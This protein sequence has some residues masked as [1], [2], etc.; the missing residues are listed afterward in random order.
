MGHLATQFPKGSRKNRKNKKSTR[1]IGS[2]D[3]RQVISKDRGKNQQN[4]GK[5]AQTNPHLQPTWLP[6]EMQQETTQKST[7]E[8]SAPQDSDHG[9]RDLQTPQSSTCWEDRVEGAEV[10]EQEKVDASDQ[11]NPGPM[12]TK[13]NLTF[14]KEVWTVVGQKKKSQETSQPMIT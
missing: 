10:L 4:N 8:E 3:D 9:L 6:Q 13:N 2:N 14:A 5:L 11:D 12:D 7:K 1:W